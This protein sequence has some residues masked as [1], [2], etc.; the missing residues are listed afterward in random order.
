[1]MKYKLSAC[2]QYLL[3]LVLTH[4]QLI[5]ILS[6]LSLQL[7]T[8]DI[9][10]LPK[11]FLYT[12]R[13]FQP[14]SIEITV[15]KMKWSLTLFCPYLSKVKRSDPLLTYLGSRACNIFVSDFGDE[16][17]CLLMPSLPFLLHKWAGPKY[18]YYPYLLSLWLIPLQFSGSDAKSSLL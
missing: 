8:L 6:V 12:H 7:L 4:L 10:S 18:C 16:T 5:W 2:F 3:F 17:I 9:Q 13:L 1:M 15:A 14:K 11:T